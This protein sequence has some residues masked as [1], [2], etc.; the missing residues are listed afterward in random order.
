[1]P[2]GDLPLLARFNFRPLTAPTM[3]PCELMT[4]EYRKSRLYGVGSLKSTKQLWRQFT[5]RNIGRGTRTKHCY[6]AS[7]AKNATTA[8]S[9]FYFKAGREL[10]CRW[11]LPGRTQACSNL[12]LLRLVHT[13][14]QVT[15]RSF[16]TKNKNCAFNRKF[17]HWKVKSRPGLGQDTLG[18]STRQ[19]LS[20]VRSVPPLYRFSSSF[21]ITA[22]VTSAGDN[23]RQFW[24]LT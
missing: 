9:P 14:A 17:S 12:V 22:E 15:V 16:Q 20:H 13:M 18:H 1:M 4:W 6:I 10:S 7:K 11:L 23:R 2:P 3:K 24:W 5:F 21:P 19:L 8:T